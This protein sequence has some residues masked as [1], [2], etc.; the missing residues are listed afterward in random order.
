VADPTNS[1][2]AGAAERPPVLWREELRRALGSLAQGGKAEDWISEARMLS[3]K[4]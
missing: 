2:S 4:G 1:T 3:E